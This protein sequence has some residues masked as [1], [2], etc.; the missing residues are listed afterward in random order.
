MGKVMK[1]GTEGVR[2]RCWEEQERWPDG[3]EN[4]WRSATDR[5]EELGNLKDIP[6]TC[7]K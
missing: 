7:D 3:H 5:G 6:V 2:I 1:M 4:E